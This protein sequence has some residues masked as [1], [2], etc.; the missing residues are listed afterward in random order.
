MATF[1]VINYFKNI[2]KQWELDLGKITL[3]RKYIKHD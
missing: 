3:E 2:K 1:F